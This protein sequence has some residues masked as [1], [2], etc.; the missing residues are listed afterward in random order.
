[1]VHPPTFV[2]D[3]HR[4]RDRRNQVYVSNPA[5]QFRNICKE[6]MEKVVG[7]GVG[8]RADTGLGGG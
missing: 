7:T 4:T 6:K 2:K 8:S 3:V 5:F 1:M